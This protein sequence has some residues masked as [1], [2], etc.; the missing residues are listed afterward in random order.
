MRVLRFNV[1]MS[2][3]LKESRSQ[4]MK[5]NSVSDSTMWTVL[6]SS[7][8]LDQRD[9]CTS[10]KETEARVL[11]VKLFIY[12]LGFGFKRSPWHFGVNANK[13]IKQKLK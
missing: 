6:R 7:K 1:S 3:G 2:K 5:F 4:I 10:E 13:I 12:V 8:E 11:C 9:A